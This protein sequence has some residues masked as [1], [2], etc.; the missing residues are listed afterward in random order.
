MNTHTA[1][2]LGHWFVQV[3]SG[4]GNSKWFELDCHLY[5]CRSGKKTTSFFSENVIEKNMFKDSVRYV[6]PM[7]RITKTGHLLY[8][9]KILL[10]ETPLICNFVQPFFMWPKKPQLHQKQGYIAIKGYNQAFPHIRLAYNSWKIHMLNPKVMEVW[11]VRWFSGFQIFVGDF[12]GGLTRRSFSG[13]CIGSPP[14]L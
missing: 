8:V 5:Q 14:S 10:K 11:F 13:V 3:S 6:L 9:K 7:F 2:N 12:L 4:S 1:K